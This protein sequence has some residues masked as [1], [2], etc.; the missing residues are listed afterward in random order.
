M[1]LTEKGYDFIIINPKNQVYKGLIQGEPSFS[2][3]WNEAKKLNDQ[4]QLNKIQ[5][6]Y[7]MKLEKFE[8]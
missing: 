5:R 3:D 8:L 7:Y 4:E 6:G 2:D 1:K